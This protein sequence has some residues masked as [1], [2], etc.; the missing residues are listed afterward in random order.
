MH[1]G[2]GYEEEME[3][4]KNA[5]EVRL[6]MVPECGNWIVAGHPRHRRGA[7]THIY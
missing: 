7:L 4:L 5:L 3:I 2:S 1:Y 6:V